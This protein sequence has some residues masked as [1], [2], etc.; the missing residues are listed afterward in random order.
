M[1]HYILT[2]SFIIP[3]YLYVPGQKEDL[4]GNHSSSPDMAQIIVFSS[5]KIWLK[6]RIWM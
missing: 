1:S 5:G 6:S 3:L 4:W 2:G